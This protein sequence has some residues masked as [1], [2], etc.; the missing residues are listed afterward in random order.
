MGVG[1][2]L[3]RDGDAT[4]YFSTKGGFILGSVA[5]VLGANA[6]GSVVNAAFP[7]GIPFAYAVNVPGQIT[8][9]ATSFSGATLNYQAPPEGW[10]GRLFYGIWG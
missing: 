1:L 7:V 4:P 5:L 6:T 10:Q 9:L 2:E 8:P 3:Y